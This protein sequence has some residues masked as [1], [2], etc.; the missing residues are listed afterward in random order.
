MLV[1]NRDN[2][3]RNHGFLR[4]SNDW[5]LSPAFDVNLN[6]HKEVHVL[7]VPAMTPEQERGN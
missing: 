5:A 1:A 6:P 7:G 3:L 4:Y 2:H